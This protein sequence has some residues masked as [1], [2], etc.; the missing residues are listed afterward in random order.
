MTNSTPAQINSQRNSPP[1]RPSPPPGSRK[2]PLEIFGNG[3]EE[4]MELDGQPIAEMARSADGRE[5]VD[6]VLAERKARFA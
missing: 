2:L 5:G 1:A 6:A 4:Q 3:L